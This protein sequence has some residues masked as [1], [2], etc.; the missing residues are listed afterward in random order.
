MTDKDSKLPEPTY[1]IGAVS[2][3]TGIPAETLRVWERRYG[4]VEPGRAEGRFRMYSRDDVGRLSLIKQLVD[5]GNAIGSVANLSLEQLR[6]RLQVHS[7]RTLDPSVDIE[8]SCRVAILGDVLPPRISTQQGELG[9]IEIAVS[10]QDRQRF[11]T[12][13]REKELDLLVLEYPTI[14]LR[15]VSDVNEL[16]RLSGASHAVVIY[17]FGRSETVNRLVTSRVMP[18]RAPVSMAELQRACLGVMARSPLP[19]D[20]SFIVTGPIPPRL[21]DNESLG[22]I[23]CASTTVE[24]ECPHHLADLIM[25]LGAF[26]T[27]SAECESRNKEDAALH[28]HLHVTTAQAR[29]MLEKAL[30]RLVEAERLEF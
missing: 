23:A 6:D 25:S 24:C 26:E 28:A 21:Y 13:V 3:L 20:T 12:Q 15:T 1:R 29:S 2:R 22:K 7:N 8:R 11:E 17:G 10:Q 5:A 19:A 27:Y 9:E 30:E 4:V 16:L 18:L 14:N